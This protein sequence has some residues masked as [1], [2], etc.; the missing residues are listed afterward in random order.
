[1]R[2]F[3]KGYRWLL[4]GAI[5]ALVMPLRAAE[6]D[7]YLPGE[8]EFVGSINFK[9]ITDSTI[10]K[11]HASDKVREKLKEN[12]E[13]SRVLESLGFD[14]LKDLTSVTVAG[15]SLD[16]DGKSF[17]IAHGT[18]DLAKFDAKAEEEAKNHGDI[19]KIHKEGERKIYEVK[20]DPGEDKPLFIGLVD[21]T[22][23][24]ASSEKDYVLDC[25][26][27]AAGK[28]KSAVKKELQDLI[29]K[30]D[31]KSMWFVMPG[32]LLGKG[33][34]AQVAQ[35]DEKAKKMIDKVDS[36][37]FGI[38]I[39]KDLKLALAIGAKSAENA[40]ELAEDL[41]EK[42]SEAKGFLAFAASNQKQL[43]PLVDLV[44]SAKVGTDGSS[45][46]FKGEASEEL[47]EK[48]LKHDK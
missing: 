26:A 4:A 24:V 42:L 18:F 21:K 23:L 36:L 29:E 31:G 6:I 15:S 13:V 28:K 10:F 34:I 17:I 43:E 47:I 48:A 19:L 1:M 16:P 25:F 39:E 37:S 30:T 22:T 32:S 14:P 20:V 44:N 12:D 38:T 41:K 3:A 8:A 40:K 46:T 35:Q 33:P 5:L 45:V 2:F 27:K 11:K 9:Q 7:K